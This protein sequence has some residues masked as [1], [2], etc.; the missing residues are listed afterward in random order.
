MRFLLILLLFSVSAFATET[1]QDSTVSSSDVDSVSPGVNFYFG[2]AFITDLFAV[3]IFGALLFDFN[4]EFENS[5][6]GS[7]IVNL[8]SVMLF[9]D[10]V[11]DEEDVKKWEGYRSA[12]STG[13][14]YRQ[15]LGRIKWAPKKVRV[16]HRNV[17]ANSI[18][19]F[20]QSMVA[21]SFKWAHDKPY[22]SK[23]EAEHTFDFGGSAEI[24]VGFV[25]NGDD[26]LSNYGLNVGYQY[27]D[28]KVRHILDYDESYIFI[29]GFRSKG[30]YVLLEI[31]FGF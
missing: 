18:S 4:V 24:G 13:A 17:P 14:G 8:S 10:Y 30:F 12:W 6:S 7:V 20:A 5:Y 26:F 15:Y 21:P 3:P 2:P 23:K 16:K 9:C 1:A 28:E 27:W 11:A 19:F 25:F 31:K 22:Q 29:R